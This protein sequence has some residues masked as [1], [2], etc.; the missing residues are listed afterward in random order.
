MIERVR[1]LEPRPYVYGSELAVPELPVFDDL[2]R[3][4]EFAIANMAAGLAEAGRG[5]AMRFPNLWSRVGFVA[6]LTATGFR[7]TPAAFSASQHAAALFEHMRGRLDAS[8]VDVVI[9]EGS[10][11]P[12][13][14]TGGLASLHLADGRA[15]LSFRLGLGGRRRCAAVGF[16]LGAPAPLQLRA[17]VTADDD[18]SAAGAT[19]FDLPSGEVLAGIVE[20]ASRPALLSAVTISVEG[21]AEEV[22]LADLFVV[23]YG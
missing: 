8:L 15:R 9:E 16:V 12:G 5:P 23:T 4:A 3:F 19:T 14:G 2:G 18:P 22:V 1:S 13:D 10:L 21:A 7:P 11:Q 6:D 20:V 17:E